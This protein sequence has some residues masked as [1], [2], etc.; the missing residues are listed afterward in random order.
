MTKGQEAHSSHNIFTEMI[1][2]YFCSIQKHR[3]PYVRL[4]SVVL[5]RVSRNCHTKIETTS[6]SRTWNDICRSSVRWLSEELI[7]KNDEKY[8]S[9][10][11]Q[12]KVPAQ[13]LAYTMPETTIS[14]CSFR[15]NLRVST[16]SLAIVERQATAITA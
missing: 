2:I 6:G 16:S 12:S 14:F 4:L 15:A 3:T 1:Q 11:L 5:C 8:N 7:P 13:K 10:G 9:E